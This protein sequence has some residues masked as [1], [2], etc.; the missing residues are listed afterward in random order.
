ME[1]FFHPELING[2]CE[3]GENESRHIRVL[4]KKP[5]DI[6]VLTDGMGHRA[7]CVIEEAGPKKC[8]VYVQKTESIERPVPQLILAVSPLKN[9]DR[10]EWLIEKCTESGVGTI[11]PL[12]CER[13]EAM[14]KKTDRLQRIIQAATIQSLQYFMPVLNQ[15]VRFEDFLSWFPVGNKLIAW[16]EDASK[17]P[18]LSA[19][20]DGS[21]AII[22]IGPEGDF[23]EAEFNMAVQ[24]GYHAISLGPNRLRTETA[25][26]L[27]AHAFYLMNRK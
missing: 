1:L 15:P 20:K 26:V 9:P 13:T 5:G 11:V 21:D 18:I 4:R 7:E 22:L 6:I 19:L 25:A 8:M 17:T 14:L 16:C 2:I 24:A 10:F 27:A 3:L 23:T 12:V